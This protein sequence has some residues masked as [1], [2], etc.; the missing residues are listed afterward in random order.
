MPG[1]N[2]TRHAGIVTGAENRLTTYPQSTDAGRLA[3]FN[4]RVLADCLAEATA[5]YWERRAQALLDA[6][7]RP[8]DYTGRAT[9]AELS[10]ARQRCL[11]A[12]A[13]CR[14]RASLE[15][16]GLPVPPIVVAALAEGVTPWA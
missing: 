16:P 10:A 6:A 4:A 8:G 3:H 9:A 14:A 1:K 11:D 5:S 7:P 2:N 13:A 12:A 15:G